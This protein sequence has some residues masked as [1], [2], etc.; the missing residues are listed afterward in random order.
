LTV[1]KCHLRL[2]PTLKS[3]KD[4]GQLCELI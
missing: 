1:G 2:E 4:S 3:I